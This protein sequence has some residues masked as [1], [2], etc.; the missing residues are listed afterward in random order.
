MSKHSARELHEVTG[1]ERSPEVLREAEE[2]F[3]GGMN[4]QAL[5][6]LELANG[7]RRAIERGESVAS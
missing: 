6:R 3:L 1:I 5:E 7:L 4:T 2:R